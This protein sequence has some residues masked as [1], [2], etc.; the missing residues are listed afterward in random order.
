MEGAPPPVPK[1]FSNHW[2]TAEKFFQSLEKIRPFFQ[3]LEKYFPIIGK[4]LVCS[5]RLRRGPW[6]ERHD[7]RRVRKD[8]AGKFRAIICPREAR[9]GLLSPVRAPLGGGQKKR[10]LGRCKCLIPRVL[11]WSQ[12]ADSNRRPSHYECDVI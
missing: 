4:L 1:I 9:F 5:E 2:K 6:A 8:R 10:P 3:P 12:R 11:K 7:A